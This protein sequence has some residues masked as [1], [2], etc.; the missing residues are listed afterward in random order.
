MKNELVRLFPKIIGKYYFDEHSKYEEEWINKCLTLSKTI[1]PGGKNWINTV[2]NTENTYNLND[3]NKFNPLIRFLNESAIDYCK[4][5]KYAGNL[6]HT[7]SFFNIY[8]KGDYQEWHDHPKTTLSG[9]YCLGGVEGAADILFTDFNNNKVITPV[10]EYVQ[11]NSSTWTEIFEPGKFLIFRSDTLHC[12]NKHT[13]DT[14]RLSVAT[15]F[16]IQH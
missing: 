10:S 1:E 8:Q 3:D 4:K 16:L 6:V 13:L 7:N 14:P 5:L 12:V 11:D 9:I 15:N 2:Y